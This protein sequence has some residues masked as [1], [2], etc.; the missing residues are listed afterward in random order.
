VLAFFFITV[1][2]IKIKF[3]AIIYIIFLLLV[4]ASSFAYGINGA[5][6]GEIFQLFILICLLT[7]QFNSSSHPLI[8]NFLLSFIAFSFIGSLIVDFFGYSA[9]RQNG[10]EV[11]LF[12]HWFG[13]LAGYFILNI[14][15]ASYPFNHKLVLLIFF[16][17]SFY[18][19]I[20]TIQSAHI[21][22][23]FLCMIIRL[24]LFE[25]INF[26]T[27]FLTGAITFVAFAMIQNDLSTVGLSGD[28]AWAQM[29]FIQSFNLLGFDPTTLANSPLIRINEFLSLYE[30]SNIS[31]LLFGRGY[32]STYSISGA[33]W[34][35]SIL[36]EATF[37]I[38]Q[39]NSGRLQLVHESL[40]LLFKWTGIIGI[41]VI[42]FIFIR[43]LKSVGLGFKNLFFNVLLLSLF[44]FSG[45][46]TGLL[47]LMLIRFSH[48]RTQ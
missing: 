33:F 34:H 42:Y 31:Q 2:F 7:M 45:V 12:G 48:A 5:L 18:V 1:F 36:H 26:R 11:F 47:C 25:Q 15:T 30:Q 8:Q 24:G 28:Y 23:I 6:T 22:F 13:I 40:V 35:L 20:N 41:I 29:K 19:N 27:I 38:D 21:I 3:D 43:K 37:P 39:I 4:W 44:L 14:G 32:A 16:I 46:H 17:I 9:I 10:G